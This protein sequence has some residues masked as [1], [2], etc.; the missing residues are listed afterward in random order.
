MARPTREMPSASSESMYLGFP[1]F[2]FYLLFNDVEILGYSKRDRKSH[3][4][5]LRFL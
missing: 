1:M 4:S 5:Q 3:F 2:V